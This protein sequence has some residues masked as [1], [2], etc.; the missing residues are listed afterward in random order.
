MQ[1]Q[2]TTDK[3]EQ[4]TLSNL[5]NI[6]NF[7]AG[8]VEKGSKKRIEILTDYFENGQNR[9]L[10]NLSKSFYAGH[11]SFSHPDLASFLRD[12]NLITVNDLTG[13]TN[14]LAEKHP[15]ALGF[16]QPLTA[17]MARNLAITAD[18]LF[19]LLTED[20]IPSEITTAAKKE[21][22]EITPKEAMVI[23]LGE[24]NG[25]WEDINAVYELVY[26]TKGWHTTNSLKQQISD[27]L[28][29]SEFKTA[30]ENILNDIL[31]RP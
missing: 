25:R 20:R 11:R 17:P 3:C 21:R 7:Q 23:I 16:K 27:Y 5:R 4:Q 19:R 14:W 24:Y 9:S 28:D 6:G 29:A 10:A 30:G 13:L 2:T 31:R 12:E 26:Q 8:G 1:L 15:Q 18:R 22:K